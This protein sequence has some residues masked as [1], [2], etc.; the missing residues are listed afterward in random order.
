MFTAFVDSC[1]RVI[2]VMY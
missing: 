1:C 2:D